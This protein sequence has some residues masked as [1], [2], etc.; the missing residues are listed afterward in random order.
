MEL[1]A[2]FVQIIRNLGG[3][4]AEVEREWKQKEVVPIIFSLFMQTKNWLENERNH[5]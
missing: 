4:T 1:K 2:Y 3:F 5:I